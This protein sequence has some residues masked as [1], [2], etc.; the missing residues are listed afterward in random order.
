MHADQPPR[1]PARGARLAAEACGVRR[2][3]TRQVVRVEDLTAVQIRQ[4]NLGGG[5]QPEIITLDVIGVV[6]ELR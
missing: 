1:V 2:V 6:G 3:V 5:Y 4:R